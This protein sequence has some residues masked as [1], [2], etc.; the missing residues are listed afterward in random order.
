[1]DHY[2]GIDVSPERLS[3]CIMDV[4]GRGVRE[5]EVARARKLVTTRFDA[6]DNP[7]QVFDDLDRLGRMRAMSRRSDRSAVSSRLCTISANMVSLPMISWKERVCSSACR[8]GATS[9]RAGRCA[10]ASR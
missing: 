2:V 6:K 10:A 9:H 5:A 1:M 7:D 4:T 3:A 8:S